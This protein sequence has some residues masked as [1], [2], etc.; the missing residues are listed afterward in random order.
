MYKFEPGK[1][2]W[3]LGFKEAVLASFRFLQ[4]SFKPITEEVTFIR[5]ESKNAFVNV[6]HGR[7]SFEVGVEIGRL[8]RPQ[9]YGLDYI[10]SWAGKDAW[11]AE[12]FGRST[13]F[14]ASN[15]GGVQN[16]VQKVARLVEKY[17]GPFLA[18]DEAFYDELERANERAS[19]KFQREQLIGQIT[20]ETDAAW[21]AKDFARVVELLQPIRHELTKI[22]AKK[23]A[24]AEKHIGSQLHANRKT[25]R[26]H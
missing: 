13:M 12:G 14:Q 3:K 9:K 21:V 8:D 25:P 18:G 2:R 7:G 11:E 17:V 15:K 24:Y 4:L 16:I 1:D 10:V 26:R 19:L 5:Y 22:D 6:Y 23:L 20:K